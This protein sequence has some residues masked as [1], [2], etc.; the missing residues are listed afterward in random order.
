[1]AIEEVSLVE[2]YLLLV[3]RVCSGKAV[4]SRPKPNNQLTSNR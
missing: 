4:H 1:M 3:I 2:G